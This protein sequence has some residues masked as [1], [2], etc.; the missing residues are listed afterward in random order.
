MFAYVQHKHVHPSPDRRFESLL[1]LLHTCQGQPFVRPRRF[2]GHI[3]TPK[4][5][6]A[7]NNKSP[8]FDKQL[9]GHHWSSAGGT[10]LTGLGARRKVCVVSLTDG[11]SCRCRAE[12]GEFLGQESGGFHKEFALVCAADSSQILGFDQFAASFQNKEAFE[13]KDGFR[14]EI[15]DFQSG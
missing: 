8:S 9:C 12:A 7:T 1:C 14:D 15:R 5:N 10:Q 11:T 6:Q 13:D 4:V 2:K 3:Q